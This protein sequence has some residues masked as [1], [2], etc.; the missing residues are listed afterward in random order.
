MSELPDNVENTVLYVKTGTA[1][2][3]L[4]HIEIRHLGARWKRG[5][6]TNLLVNRAENPIVD[7]QAEGVD[8]GLLFEQRCRR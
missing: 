3:P 4:G 6:G 7:L 2:L 1:G 5:C 8:A